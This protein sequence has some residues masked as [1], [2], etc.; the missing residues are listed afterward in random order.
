MR[1][2]RTQ[3]ARQINT[4][5]LLAYWRIGRMIVVYEQHG[6]DRAKCGERTL[7][8]LSKRLK[9]KL[10][11]GFSRT[12]LQYMRLLYQWH[13]I[14]QTLSVKLSWSHYCTLLD[15]PEPA[16]RGFYEREA[17]NAGWSVRE[18][19]RHLRPPPAQ[20]G[21]AGSPSPTNPRPPGAQRVNQKGLSLLV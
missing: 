3:A 16:K 6:S 21:A 11:K 17:E 12:N 7:K 2:A 15:L 13:P 18:L 14:C 8:E 19:R 10:G 1:E 4:G 9:D 5:Q 20:R